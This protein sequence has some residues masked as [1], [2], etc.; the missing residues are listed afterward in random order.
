MNEPS[1]GISLRATYAGIRKVEKD[2]LALIVSDAPAVG[3]G[4]VH[5]ES[6][7]GG[8]GGVARKNLRASRGRMQA[9][10]V[11][12]GNANCATRTGEQ[13]ALESYARSGRGAG[14]SKPEDVLPASTGVIGVEM[15]GGKIVDALPKLKRPR[16]MQARFRC[17]RGG[18]PD[19]RPRSKTAFAEMKGGKP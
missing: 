3:R 7:G 4:G 14:R 13:V 1:A 16:S 10:L 6:G 12:A 19:H 2:D 5:E 9:I 8:A 11:N 17:R 18:D 15:D